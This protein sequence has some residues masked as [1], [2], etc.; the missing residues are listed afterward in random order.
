MALTERNGI[1][2]WSKVFQGHTFARSTKTGDKK[3]GTQIE[4]RCGDEA[5]QSILVR[6]TKPVLCSQ[7][8]VSIKPLY[9]DPPQL[10][11]TQVKEQHQRA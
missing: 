3:L 2:H 4:A 10:P 5:V 8:T 11:Q 1:W 7:F 9:G 6:G